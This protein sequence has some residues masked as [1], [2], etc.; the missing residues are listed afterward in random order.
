MFFLGGTGGG[1]SPSPPEVTSGTGRVSVGGVAGGAG[2][3]AAG[4][5]LR[6]EVEGCFSGSGILRITGCERWN[7]K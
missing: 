6:S 2:G 5:G 1:T 7:Y 3:G 4:L